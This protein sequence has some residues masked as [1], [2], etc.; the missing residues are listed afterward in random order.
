ME[1]QKLIL[2]VSII[3]AALVIGGAL[4]YTQVSPA[5]EES[6]DFTT[7]ETGKETSPNVTKPTQPTG[8]APVKD[9]IVTEKDHVKGNVNAPVTI[10]EYSDFQCPFC[11]R[12]H[13]TVQ[14]ALDEYQGQVRWVYRHFPLG[15]H[16]EARPAAEASECAAEQG[17][18]WEFTDALFENQDRLGSSLYTELAQNLGLN[19]T[20]FGDCV[21]SRKYE[22]RVESDYQRG[23]ELG[24]RGT[25]G[26]FV[27]G[28]EVPGAVPYSN[29]N[30]P[31][32]KERIEKALSEL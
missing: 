13:P 26:S 14:R 28:E 8:P 17:K 3:F 30:P 15:G 18:F 22:D 31:G 11:Q 32:L 12:F 5:P 2:P 19:V 7:E 4:I 27:N 29:S 21:S 1:T 23:V 24:V 25:P 20:Q 10:V 16:P 6:S 9:I